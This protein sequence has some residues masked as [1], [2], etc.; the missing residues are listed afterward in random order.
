MEYRRNI[1]SLFKALTSEH[2][3][4]LLHC[5]RVAVLAEKAGRKAADRRRKR[6]VKAVRP[7]G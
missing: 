6:R 1:N 3:A 2:Q 5:V 7:G 4:Q